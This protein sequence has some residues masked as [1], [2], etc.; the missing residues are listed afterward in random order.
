MSAPAL[1]QPKM[2]N[3]VRKPPVNVQCFSDD[4][5]VILTLKD[6]RK[7]VISSDSYHGILMAGNMYKC[8]FCGSEMELDNKLKE[9]HKNLM[10]HKRCLERYPHLEDFSE[11]LIR[12]LSN[13]SLY[14]SLCNVVMTTTAATRHV[15]TETHKDQ[16]EK[17]EIKATTYKPI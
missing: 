16:L 13:D 2:L 17:A 8:V 7:L 6:C 12:K 1:R 10:T 14:C 11:N 9:A 5:S 3:I 4:Q 15:T